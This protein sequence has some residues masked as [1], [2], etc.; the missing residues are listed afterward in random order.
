MKRQLACRQIDIGA[1]AR[2]FHKSTGDPIG[3]ITRDES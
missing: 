1:G 3:I 2:Y